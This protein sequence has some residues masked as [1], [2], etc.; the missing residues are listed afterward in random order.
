MNWWRHVLAVLATGLLLGARAQP[1]PPVAD[2]FDRGVVQGVELSPDGRQLAMVVH[3][4]GQRGRLVVVDTEKM[5]AKVAASFSNGD[6]RW[7]R[8]INDRRLVFSGVGGTL[9]TTMLRA[10]NSDGTDM[11]DALGERVSGRWRYFE[12]SPLKNS[13]SIYLAIDRYDVRGN[14]LRT[15]LR[16]VDTRDKLKG[17]MLKAPG[18]TT[19]WLL[20]ADGQ[21]AIVTARENGERTSAHYRDPATKEWR[22]LFEFDTYGSA[23]ILPLAMNPARR[24]ALYV[25]ANNGSDKGALHVFDLETG[26]LDP[27]PLVSVDRYDFIGF[28]LLHA[29]RVVGF[30]YT[31]DARDQ[32]WVDPAF[33]DIQRR[34]DALLPG[35]INLVESAVRNQT[36]KLLVVAYSDR[37]PYAFYLF[38]SSSGKLVPLGQR[39][40]FIDARQ[41]ARMEVVSYAG[42][43]GLPIPARLTFPRTGTRNLPMVVLAPTDAFLR[44]GSWEWDAQAQFLASR[45]Y[46]VLQPAMR[47]SRGFGLN[48]FKSGWKQ[49]GLDMQDDFA[50]GA[51]WA[52]KEGYA[53][54]QRICIAG[55]GF[56][57]YTAL[58]GAAREPDLYRCVVAMQPVTD[59]LEYT[60]N[61][62]FFSA[63][64]LAFGIPKMIGDPDAD[65]QALKSTSP[66]ALAER[67]KRPVFLAH[68]DRNRAIPFFHGSKM[69]DALQAN[70][71]PVEWV[72]Y[73]NDWTPDREFEE[74]KDA[75]ARIEQF[76]ARQLAAP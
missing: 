59:L 26:K 63:E 71:T 53:D 7:F 4:R 13:D 12:A 23:A 41:M 72:S 51:R 34:I 46:A 30:R 5:T 56:G 35:T 16:E 38:D 44:G 1:A 6:V 73:S 11:T 31:G 39:R 48:H 50:A 57:G 24:D 14:Y 28:P 55:T 40:Q 37:Q 68:W 43:D 36:S 58:M 74:T 2:F 54:A 76:L 75:W 49:W 60:S 18:E 8:W 62:E 10:V 33:K 17:G 20:D 67:I 47:G 65:A 66:L 3:P 27:K 45:G 32:V 22:K 69:R 19:Y 70:G 61:W 21:P 15:D 29:G 9:N 42:K 64:I 25:V 52:V